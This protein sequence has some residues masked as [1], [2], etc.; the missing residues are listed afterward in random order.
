MN[1]LLP[2]EVKGDNEGK[3]ISIHLSN[4]TSRI[5]PIQPLIALC[6]TA[7]RMVTWRKRCG[8]ATSVGDVG[9]KS[10]ETTAE[11]SDI[12]ANS[13]SEALEKESCPVMELSLVEFDADATISFLE[14][15]ISLHYHERTIPKPQDKGEVDALSKQHLLT[16]IDNGM[17]SEIHIV[18]CLKLAHY[19]QCRIVL[20]TLASI[21]ERS[22]D[23]HNCIAFCSLADAMSLKSL[24]EA[25]VNFVIE[26]L[27]AL[28][29]SAVKESDDGAL[30]SCSSGC[31]DGDGREEFNEVWTS[32][33][34]DLRSRVLTM[35]NVLRSSVIGRG[36]KVSGLF[37]S[38]AT[39]F[40]AIFLETIRDHEERLAEAK[41]RCDELIRERSDEWADMCHRR[42]PWF[43][44]SAKAQK[45]FVYG[46]DVVFSLEK[47]QKQSKRLNTLRSFYEDQKIIFK[48]GGFGS[49]IIL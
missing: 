17:I 5:Y 38:S 22:I 48:G 8:S 40:L 19:L 24:F 3:V 7:T 45:E 44:R 2:P 18:E 23:A 26:R 6:E 10:S 42:G 35:R 33:P 39:E 1:T 49:E 25:S 36:S 14:V 21:V 47:I 46:T 29:G 27:D 4:N 34:H 32:L 43:D 12:I 20:D 41:T 28:Q 9:D 16:L 15:V 31:D 13:A 30:S 37:F 11:K